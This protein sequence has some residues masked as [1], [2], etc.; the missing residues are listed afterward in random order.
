MDLN[1]KD[2]EMERMLNKGFVLAVGIAMVLIAGCGEQQLPSEKKS[3]LIAIENAELKKEIAQ[4]D[5]EL[6]NLKGR[7]ARDVKQREQQLT[8]CKKQ[9]ENCKEDLHGK[10][11]K[12]MDE[13]FEAMMEES[14]KVQAENKGLKAEIAELKTKLEEKGQSK[15]V[16]EREKQEKPKKRKVSEKRE[17]R[18]KKDKENQVSEGAAGV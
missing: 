7:H 10:I 8:E 1:R 13:V 16:K 17:G 12:R 5:L 18:K 6:E 4:R 9:N 3:R 2:S 15:G 11:E 14:A